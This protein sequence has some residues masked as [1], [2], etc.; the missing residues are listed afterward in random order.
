MS[1]K[2]FAARVF[3]TDLEE[4][5]QFYAGTLKLP[6]ED[7]GATDGYLVFS[8]PEGKSLLVQLMAQPPAGAKRTTSTR[9]TA[10]LNSI[11]HAWE[12]IGKVEQKISELEMRAAAIADLEPRK[13]DKNEQVEQELAE[14]KKDA[15]KTRVKL[16]ET[17]LVIEDEKKM[18]PAVRPGKNSKL[19]RRTKKD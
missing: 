18:L 15:K 2:T 17:T 7:D 11:D 19:P 3:V 13:S 6:L 8:A 9:A 1:N 4:A 12:T 10:N 16:G 5:R 14:L